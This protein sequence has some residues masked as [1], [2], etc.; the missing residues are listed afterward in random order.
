MISIN[1][2][3]EPLNKLTQIFSGVLDYLSHVKQKVVRGN[4]APFMTKDLSKTIMMKLKAKSQNG[5][6]K[7]KC[8]SINKRATKDY[9]VKNKH[10]W[11]KLKPFLPN[12]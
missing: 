10:F 2:C 11:E 5:K 1:N 3:Q 7:N 12:K 8:T 9:L 6:A 4:Q